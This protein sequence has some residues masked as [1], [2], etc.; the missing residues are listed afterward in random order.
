[1]QFMKTFYFD[2]C[3]LFNANAFI[4]MNEKSEPND[5]DCENTLKIVSKPYLDYF[6]RKCGK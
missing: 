3:K 4:H 6:P 2:A 5:H 1:M